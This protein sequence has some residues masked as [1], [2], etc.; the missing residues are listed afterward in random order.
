MNSGSSLPKRVRPDDD[1]RDVFDDELRY[2]HEAPLVP[3]GLH[4]LI[5]DRQKRRSTAENYWEKAFACF[6]VSAVDCFQ[7]TDSKNTPLDHLDAH[8]GRLVMMS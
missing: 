7:G 6:A 5:K 1:R 2:G 4:T 8:V 3:G